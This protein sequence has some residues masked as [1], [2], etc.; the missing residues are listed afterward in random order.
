[1]N[2]QAPVLAVLGAVALAAAGCGATSEAVTSAKASHVAARTATTAGIQAPRSSTTQGPSSSS[3][4]VPSST[5]TTTAPDYGSVDRSIATAV[6]TAA[7]T[8]NWTS[9]TSSDSGPFA[10]T[11][12]SLIWYTP[13]AAAKVRAHPPT[14]PVGEQWERWAAHRAVTSAGL[15][16]TPDAGAPPDTATAAYRSFAVT[17]TA[18]GQDGWTAVPSRYQC[19]V[20][21]TRP[22]A[23]APWQVAGFE[24]TQ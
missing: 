4:S 14:G 17:V 23:T 9:N 21:L 19:F 10:A 6:A 24:V 22:S 7:V 11:L 1:M 8:A 3:T 16:A 15:Q 2:H 13:A 12:R 18:H 5:T 20:T